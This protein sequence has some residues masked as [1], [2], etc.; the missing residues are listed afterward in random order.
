MAEIVKSK[1]KSRIALEGAR[2]IEDALLTNLQMEKLFILKSIEEVPE[3]IKVLMSE[4]VEIH[5]LGQ[6]HMQLW[7]SVTTPPG[8]IGMWA[9][10]THLTHSP[11]LMR[12][13]E[14][15]YG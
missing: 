9:W 12:L 6:K 4:D 10:C 5:R 13:A 11:K 14:L 15:G 8:I 3:K 2:L 7:S 1:K